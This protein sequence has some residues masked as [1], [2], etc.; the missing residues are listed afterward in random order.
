M[1]IPSREER[2]AAPPTLTEQGGSASEDTALSAKMARGQSASMRTTFLL[3]GMAIIIFMAFTAYSLQ[4]AIQSRAQLSAIK[5]L[6]FPMLQLLNANAVRLDNIKGIYLQVVVTG[7]RDSIEKAT[8]LGAQADQAFGQV[9]ALYPGHGAVIGQLRSDLRQYQELATAAALAFLAQDLSAAPKVA[10]MNHARAGLEA[11]LNTFREASYADFVQTLAD[12]Q[13]DARIRLTLGLALGAMNLGFMAVLVFFIRNNMQMIGVIAAQKATLEIRVVE[14]TAQLSQKTSDINA[15]LQNMTLGVS[16]VVSGNRIHPEYS[17]YLRTI[18][19]VD[20]LAGKDLLATLFANSTLGEDS[21]DQIATALNTILDEDAMMF[22][23]N[24]HLLAREMAIDTADGRQKILQMD[25]IPIVGEAGCVD[26]VLLITQDVT[27]LRTLEASATQQRDE[28]AIIAQIIRA[29]SGKF[30]AFIESTNGYLAASRELIRAASGCDQDIIAALFRNMHT[31]KGNARTFEF[32]QITDAAH[33]AEQTYDRLRKDDTA[34]CNFD[35]LLTELAAVEAAVARYV[36]INDNTLGRKGRASDRFGKQGAFVS[37]DQLAELR[38]LAAA[39]SA[40]GRDEGAIRLQNVVNQLG[41]VSLARLVSG[42][43]DSLASLAKELKKPTPA[44]QI[45]NGEISFNGEFA[46]AL[47][48]CFMHI[49]RNSLDHGI[50]APADRLL[51]H[52]PEQGNMRFV[53]E[54]HG[55]FV[56]LRVSDDG[57]GLALQ[58]L[59]A[60]GVGG[61]Y[62]RTDER[63]TRQAVADVIFLAGVSTSPGV[64]QISGRG[65]GMEAVRTFLHEHGATIRIALADP[66]GIAMDFA[67]FEF[68]ITIPSA[69]CRN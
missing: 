50:E 42:S 37:S 20:D 64:T 39:L 52:K 43:T 17:S 14:R 40:A 30:N 69:A 33:R 31:I 60:K 1:E 34:K 26:K 3:V 21:K 67:P 55:E 47:R 51:A 16:T 23:M 15:M 27:H 6:Y 35:E 24:G 45:V 19:G 57:R 18:F 12:S 65:V 2:T 53:C 41:L 46:E 36:D 61:G 62:F 10:K 7:D 9:A 66:A 54:R 56:E 13:R 4:K 28:L 63:P 8:Q 32:A 59:Y 58:G 25:W 38:S 22:A 48:S 49:Q 29:S 5:D 11:R 68:V 44:V